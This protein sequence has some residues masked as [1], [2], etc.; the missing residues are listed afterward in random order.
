MMKRWISFLVTLLLAVSLATT[1]MAQEMEESA[2]QPRYTGI[3]VYSADL[4][5]SGETLLLTGSITAWDGYTSKLTIE[6]QERNGYSGSWHTKNT[7]TDTGS[8]R[9]LC[10]IDERI[11]GTA[12]HSYRG[13]CKFQAFDASGKVVD[14]KYEYTTILYL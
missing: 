12:G 7:Y 5:S 3:A 11:A 1:G 13:Y 8:S 9:D 4:S 2:A 14:E 6:L 10:V